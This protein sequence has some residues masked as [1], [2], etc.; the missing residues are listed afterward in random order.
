MG[1]YGVTDNVLK[2]LELSI[3][4]YN[5]YFPMPRAGVVSKKLITEN[6]KDTFSFVDVLL[7]KTDTLVRMLALC[8][9]DF[10]RDYFNSRKVIVTG[11]DGVLLEL[12]SCQFF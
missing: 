7:S 10:Y 12:S 5:A 1:L 8:E 2:E 4:A 9:Q 6:I 11:E 3:D